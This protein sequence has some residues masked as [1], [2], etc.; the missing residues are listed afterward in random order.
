MAPATFDM[1]GSSQEHKEYMS[2]A[3][4]CLDNDDEEQE[5][6]HNFGSRRTNSRLSILNLA[7]LVIN[8]G[9]I[10]YGS[11][12]S[13]SCAGAGTH[14]TLKVPDHPYKGTLHSRNLT[15]VILILPQIGSKML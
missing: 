2:E 13:T 6:I 14:N 1:G 12:L 10:I 3:Q 4:P 9:F 8:L 5:A 15:R 11:I 7:L